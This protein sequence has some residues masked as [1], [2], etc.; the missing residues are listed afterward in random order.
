MNFPLSPKDESKMQTAFEMSLDVTSVETEENKQVA[1]TAATAAAA[2]E[3][4]NFFKL[5]A[6]PK[7]VRKSL[8]P[9]VVVAA[10]AAAAAA[11]APSPTTTPKLQKTLL[12]SPRLH[13]AIFGSSRDK[14][15]KTDATSNKAIPEEYACDDRQ[16]NSSLSSYNSSVSSD[17]SSPLRSPSIGDAGSVPPRTRAPNRP[18]PLVS[19]L[20]PLTPNANFYYSDESSCPGTPKT[21]LKPAMGVSMIGKQRRLT[22]GME[23]GPS[24]SLSPPNSAS[25]R[26]TGTYSTHFTYSLPQPKSC[27]PSVSSLFG[28]GGA[29]GGGGGG[30]GELEY[31]PVFE[32][33][34][35][36]LSEKTEVVQ[37]RLSTVPPIPAPRTKFLASC[38]NAPAPCHLPAHTNQ[39]ANQLAIS[40]MSNLE[41]SDV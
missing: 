7:F 25:A 24:P 40:Q 10:T 31:P 19:P 11:P 16:L 13:R 29:G 8:S 33:G 15:K 18:P 3:T 26:V 6:S 36:S 22:P 9:A 12:G 23:S 20:A 37:Q 1:A 35:Y 30:A 32:P 4:K 5:F 41:E 39:Q 14:R 21:P 2:S 28:G 17:F 38:A 27:S 34:T